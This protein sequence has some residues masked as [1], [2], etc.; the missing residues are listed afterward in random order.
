[1][2][3]EKPTKTGIPN[4]VEID[5]A[6][7][8]D[9]HIA[10]TNF[11][12]VIDDFAEYIALNYAWKESQ[13][14][15][16]PITTEAQFFKKINDSKHVMSKNAVGVQTGN[17]DD[18]NYDIIDLNTYLEPNE[19]WVRG[20]NQLPEKFVE[21]D[22]VINT[23][24]R[25]FF[26]ALNL[27]TDLERIVEYV[28]PL[29]VTYQTIN[30][31]LLPGEEWVKDEN[32][33]P[34][35]VIVKDIKYYVSKN[36][37]DEERYVSVPVVVYTTLKQSIEDRIGVLNSKYGSQF[38]ADNMNDEFLWHWYERFKTTHYLVRE[39]YK[40]LIGDDFTI[41][42]FED[43]N[44]SI[45]ALGR[46]FE[47]PDLTCIPSID[48]TFKMTRKDGRTTIP[49]TV[50]PNI[51]DKLD[52]DIKF[53]LLDA[54]KTVN[55]LFRR[56]SIHVI[57]ELSTP[58]KSHGTNLMTDYI[59]YSRM[60]LHYGDFASIISDTL[61]V[62]YK[63]MAFATS[64]LNKQNVTNPKLTQIVENHKMQVDKMQNKLSGIT[65]EITS[66]DLLKA[67]SVDLENL[68]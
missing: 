30:S 4:I 68:G 65:K 31:F 52:D 63:I 26:K 24:P 47:Y 39:E 48:I 11:I 23:S 55:S 61:G 35:T 49:R 42:Y 51:F 8:L 50:P 13:Q 14:S 57:D 46:L 33:F 66:S 18:V 53:V 54:S 36:L 41:N 59:H 40:K 44:D 67:D 43:F 3:A 60:S 34:K 56:H 37:E 6:N 19:V 25:I 10:S 1:M 28:P 32:G 27:M 64:A 38:G 16:D 2:P 62:S 9:F 22:V 21:Q 5:L 29:A 15:A 58:Q 17:V 20:K 7:S 45:G 12:S